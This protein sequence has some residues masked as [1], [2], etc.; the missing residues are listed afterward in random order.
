MRRRKSSAVPPPEPVAPPTVVEGLKRLYNTKIKPLE[1]LYDFNT[2]HS[3]SLASSDFDAAP[4]VLLL[5]QYSVGKTSFIRFVVWA[6]AGG[7][8]LCVFGVMITLARVL[9]ACLL[10]LV[11]SYLLGRD[12]PNQ[13]IG[14][15]PTTDRFV[16]VMNGPSD[17]HIPGNALC[18][19]V[20]QWWWCRHR[21]LFVCVCRP[22]PRWFIPWFTLFTLHPQDNMP[23]RGLTKFGTAF[24][25]RFEAAICPS[26]I[27]EK[28]IFVDTPG[29]LSGE[30]QR[31]GRSYNFV[32]VCWQETRRGCWLSRCASHPALT[33]L[34]LVGIGFN[35][36]QVVEWFAERADMI[37]LLFD[38]HK[39]DI[40]DEFKRT[41]A[42][43]KGHE[44]KV[45]VV[46]N[47]AD[48]VSHQQLMRVYV[49]SLAFA[50]SH[51]VRCD[52]TLTCWSRFLRCVTG[53][54]HSCGAW[55]RLQAHQR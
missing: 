24:L 15:E 22:D 8:G 5:G 36:C 48:R 44:D 9:A 17:R 39:L 18:V 20:C 35:S 45:R 38:A 19:Q 26:E 1:Q 12:F 4:I 6:A 16:A 23:F 43:L 28:V 41:L 42:T 2:F 7:V 11:H 55:E 32:E 49:S 40:S 27:L 14:P 50:F 47:K 13:R 46:L 52:A 54:A 31:I 21:S 51:R 34:F 30:K 33:P 10:L 53:T 3:P 25:N 29:V 37:L